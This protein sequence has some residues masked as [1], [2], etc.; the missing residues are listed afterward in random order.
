MA[1][2]VH[3]VVN[4]EQRI[5]GRSQRQNELFKRITSIHFLHLGLTFPNS[6]L[7]RR[8]GSWF[9]LPVTE[10]KCRSKTNHKTIFYSV[11]KQPEM[12]QISISD[13][14]HHNLQQMI[15]GEVEMLGPEAASQSCQTQ[16]CPS[17]QEISHIFLR[18]VMMSVFLSFFVFS[19]LCVD[20]WA[21][22]L[23]ETL[24]SVGIKSVLIQEHLSYG[25]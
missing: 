6:P 10:V 5:T 1:E 13:H 4:R 15:Q 18:H 19:P 21:H 24:V 17:G 12:Q 7:P 2:T 3:L 11:S 8:N 16:S 22:I 23:M 25:R 20:V 9:V 14:H